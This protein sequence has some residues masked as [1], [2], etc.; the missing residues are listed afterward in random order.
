MARDVLVASS[1]GRERR[2]SSRK[3]C[4]SASGYLGHGREVV[5]ALVADLSL[6][7]AQLIGDALPPPGTGV[8]LSIALPPRDITLAGRI[9]WTNPARRAAGV[10]FD[11]G[12]TRSR[13]DI[14][15]ALLTLAVEAVAPRP[16]AAILVD[17]PGRAG[18]LCR[19]LRHCGYVPVTVRTPLDAAVAVARDRARIGLAV[20]GPRPIGME[21]DIVRE[22]FHDELPAVPHLELADDPASDGDHV[23]A[24]AN[25]VRP[26]FGAA[27]AFAAK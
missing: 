17:D 3:R 2:S 6:G 18:R 26:A 7:G 5:A 22:F 1:M 20:F 11:A 4:G 14:E 25:R 27:H 16:V 19:A 10:A 24:N 9:A 8:M 13:H 21:R 15:I 23:V 12:T